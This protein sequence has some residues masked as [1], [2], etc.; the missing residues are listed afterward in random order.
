MKVN[1]YTCLLKVRN[2]T[3]KNHAN[4]RK[5]PECDGD[6]HDQ[7]IEEDEALQELEDSLNSTIDAFEESGVVRRSLMK[8]TIDVIG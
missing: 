8:M 7:W 4:M 2:A 1:A 6:T 3:E 5:E